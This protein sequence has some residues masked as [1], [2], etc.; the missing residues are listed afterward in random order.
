MSR[1]TR[2]EAESVVGA[3]RTDIDILADRL[4]AALPAEGLSEQRMFGG[5]AFMLNGNMIAVSSRRGLLV[6]V[7]KDA[8]DD[9][10]ARPGARSMEMGGRVMAGYV[11]VDPAGL[12][13]ATLRDWLQLALAF[14]RTLPPKPSEAK[15]KR[16]KRSR[17]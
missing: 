2:V 15:S 10:L 13:D 4:R 6:R 9:A 8:Y 14:V 17:K 5:I 12:S 11:F 1:S 16:T 3:P 7:G